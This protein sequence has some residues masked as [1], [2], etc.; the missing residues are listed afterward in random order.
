MSRS[1]LGIK[2]TESWVNKRISTAGSVDAKKYGKTKTIEERQQ[3]SINSPKYWT[4]KNRDDETKSK[5]SKTKLENGFSEKQK[6]ANNNTVYIYDY[7]NELINKFESTKEASNFYNVNQS[8]ISRYC[9]N[10]KI[11]NTHRFSYS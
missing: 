8:T 11:I 7:N 1:H 5:I 9:S 10:N 3:L 4:G 2:Q 6:L